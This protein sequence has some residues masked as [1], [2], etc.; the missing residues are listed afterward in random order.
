[1][2]F[3]IYIYVMI[4]SF[5]AGVYIFFRGTSNRYLNGLTIF[6]AISILMET[7]N[8]FRNKKFQNTLIIY[9]FFS[10]FEFLFYIWLLREI[11]KKP[12]PKKVFLYV[13]LIYPVVAM[14]NIFFIQGRDK[15]ASVSYGIGCLAIVVMSI[16][17][18]FELF[19]LTYSNLLKQPP[20][21]IC[22]ALLFFYC[23]SFPIFGLSNFINDFPR[24]IKHNIGT[25]IEFLN[26]FLY[27][28]FTIAFL[29]NLRTTR[30]SQ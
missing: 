29:C 3:P 28:V 6:L 12:K 19:Q 9:N 25:I 23:C 15:F 11:V 30:S 5:L 7:F 1:M 17:F 8:H 22:S 26:V 18:F 10:V 20:F 13:L 24:V 2:G 14:V 16:Y 4:L 27:A 21:W